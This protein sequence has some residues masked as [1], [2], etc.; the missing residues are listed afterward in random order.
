MTNVCRGNLVG[1]MGIEAFVWIYR[2]GE[3][4][5]L[6]FSEVIAAFGDA[7]RD[8][9]PEFGRLHVEFGSWSDSC[10]IFCGKDV[11]ET[12]RVTSLMIDRPIRHPGI[13]EAVLRVMSLGHVL[14]FFSDDTT[15][16]F[17]DIAS[18]SHFPKD[19]IASLGSPLS[20]RTPQD[21]T[22]SFDH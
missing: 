7:V 6:P 17:R 10:K 2:D 8:W 9:D 18:A 1:A 15:P 13:W 19:L 22:A 12:G 16:R 14:L 21:I 5:S 11:L 4:A 20:V 3:P